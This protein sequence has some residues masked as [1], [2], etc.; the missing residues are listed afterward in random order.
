[1]IF[2]FTGDYQDIKLFLEQLETNIYPIKITEMTIGPRTT[3][4]QSD[5]PVLPGYALQMTV[6]LYSFNLM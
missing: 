2:G 6:E 1:M 5:A 4:I 3:T